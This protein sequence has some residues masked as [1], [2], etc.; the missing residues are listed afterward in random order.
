MSKS[1]LV[2]DMPEKFQKEKTKKRIDIG[3]IMALKKA[4][5]KNKDI[6]IEMHME[7]QAV[8]GAIYHYKKKKVVE[9]VV[10]E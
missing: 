9:E 3:K 8:T 6:A 7:P 5:W 1:I 2:I 4:G 10:P